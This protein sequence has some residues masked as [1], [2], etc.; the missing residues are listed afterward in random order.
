MTR[1]WHV[2]L[3]SLGLGAL[4][5]LATIGT[6]FGANYNV[7]ESIPA[8]SLSLL[9]ASI[10]MIAG[11]KLPKYFPKMMERN[12]CLY[13]LVVY[14]ALCILGIAALFCVTNDF[15][16][17]LGVCIAAFGS[18]GI[19]FF[20]FRIA[21]RLDY[22]E[23]SLYMVLAFAECG[24]LISIFALFLRTLVLPVSLF[25]CMFVV[26]HSANQYI[27]LGI[28]PQRDAKNENNFTTEETFVFSPVALFTTGITGFIWTGT[29]SNLLMCDTDSTQGFE[30]FGACLLL[31]SLIMLID[32]V[33]GPRL[34]E[35]FLL[36]VFSLFAFF[37][38]IVLPTTEG[39]AKIL[40]AC[41]SVTLF[42]CDVIVNLLAIAEV[43]RFN[44]ISQALSFGKSLFYFFMGGSLGAILFAGVLPLLEQPFV[45]F[46]SDALFFF[47]LA[48]NIFVFKNNFPGSPE[49]ATIVV[50]PVPLS[51]KD[52]EEDNSS[53][54]DQRS[55]WKKQAD[56]IADEYHLTS[57]QKE[58]FNMLL[59]GR[60]AQFIAEDFVISYSTAKA[61]IHNIYT[62]L[63]IHSQQELISLVENAS[64]PNP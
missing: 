15:L 14:G 26:L 24:I 54:A 58:V 1:L 7:F 19:A 62:K 46:I 59:K 43:A 30:I 23:Q 56:Y 57:R 61:H 41:L 33:T 13:L 49:D 53:V 55:C 64:P 34:G 22:H 9:F 52:V 17:T 45:I 47:I 60:N 5:S 27:S 40:I 2:S 35:D 36:K 21:G 50:V 4:L 38:L 63:G 32:R 31:T 37:F 6:A 3:Q 10:G 25:L 48:M 11:S 12:N 51:V 20:V 42:T 8:A 16:R 28:N 29:A 39:L 44:Q 18:A